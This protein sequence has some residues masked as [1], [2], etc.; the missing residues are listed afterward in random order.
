MARTL[1]TTNPASSLRGDAATNH[2]PT[3]LCSLLAALVSVSAYYKIAGKV[4]WRDVQERWGHSLHHFYQYKS[5]HGGSEA[6]RVPCEEAEVLGPS[7]GRRG[8]FTRRPWRR[9]TS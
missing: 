8:R 9:G 7:A 1:A 3:H 2:N 5:Q 4:D 6:W